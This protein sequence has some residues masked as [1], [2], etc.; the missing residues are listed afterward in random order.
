[1]SALGI[2]SLAAAPLGLPENRIGALAVF[3]LRP[4]GTSRPVGDSITEIADA[5]THT[6]LLTD[7]YVAQ[8]LPDDAA[9]YRSSGLADSDG[10]AVIHQAAGMVAAQCG[11]PTSDALALIAARAFADNALVSTTARRIVERRLRL[12]AP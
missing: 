1:M 11:C 5:L 9:D 2:H 10:A 6:I 7:E 12:D 8:L 4:A 3:D